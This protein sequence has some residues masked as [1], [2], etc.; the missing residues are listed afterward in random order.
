M[1]SGHNGPWVNSRRVYELQRGKRKYFIIFTSLAFPSFLNVARNY[2]SINS[3]YKVTS[4]IHIYFTSIT[5][6]GDIS[7]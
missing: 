2:S 7:K 5:V 1:S 4:R 6:I 3:A